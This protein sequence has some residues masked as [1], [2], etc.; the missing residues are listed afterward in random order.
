MKKALI[1]ISIILFAIL[2]QLCSSGMELLTL[3]I[4]FIGLIFTIVSTLK[5]G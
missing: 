5:T 3:G 1:G 4:G 2:L